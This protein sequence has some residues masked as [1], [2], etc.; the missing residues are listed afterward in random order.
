VT[1]HLKQPTVIWKK[2]PAWNRLG[3]IGF[4]I[5]SRKCSWRVQVIQPP[6]QKP[7]STPIFWTLKSNQEGLK[8]TM[9]NNYG[10]SCSVFLL[11]EFS[12]LLC[13]N[14][15]T[16]L[17]CSWRI[18]STFPVA[19]SSSWGL[20]GISLFACLGSDIAASWSP[21]WLKIE[22]WW[23]EFWGYWPLGK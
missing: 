17:S 3:I 4:Y 12:Q 2:L 15:F 22:C 7:K 20:R 8:M 23:P 11:S 18:E 13:K 1:V 14:N 6:T 21:M 16:C 5:C 10:W 9:N 19:K